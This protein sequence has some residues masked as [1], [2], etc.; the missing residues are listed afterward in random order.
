MGKYNDAIAQYNKAIETCP[1]ENIENLAV[2]YENRAAAYEQ[3]VIKLV[4]AKHNMK[5]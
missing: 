2:F 4:I 5:I 3:L 1:K